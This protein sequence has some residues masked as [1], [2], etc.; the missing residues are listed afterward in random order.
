MERNGKEW[1]GKGGNG[2]ENWDGGRAS[3]KVKIARCELVIYERRE[4]KG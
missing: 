3:R 4:G 2:N 1:G